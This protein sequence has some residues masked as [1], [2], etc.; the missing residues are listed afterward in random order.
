[1]AR[2]RRTRTGH[3]RPATGPMNGRPSTD[4]GRAQMRRSRISAPAT[5]GRN[6]AARRSSSGWIR[7]GSGS[8]GRKVDP[9]VLKP[10]ALA[11]L[12]SEGGS[13]SVS[14]A[15]RSVAAAARLIASTSSSSTMWRGRVAVEPQLQGHAPGGA[16]AAPG[17]RRDRSAPRSTGR[18]HEDRVGADRLAIG[19]KDARGRTVL[20]RRP[21]RGPDHDPR[22]PLLG[23]PRPGGRRGGR[24][25][26]VPGREEDGG[27]AGSERRLGQ[28]DAR[29][30]RGAR[31]EAPARPRRGVPRARPQHRDR[32]SGAAGPP[33]I[34]DIAKSSEASARAGSASGC[35]GRG[36]PVPGRAGAGWRRG[37]GRRHPPRW[38]FARRA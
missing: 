28:H 11:R 21:R 3:R 38:R 24:R 36:R 30:G 14:S 16:D 31:A 8:D 32:G 25:D 19:E 13:S 26:R 23:Q 34:G 6:S 18:R 7:A 35:R 12:N 29:R 27:G 2:G 20:D 4:C 5:R 9:S 1:M 17:R 33:A 15:A 37:C 22:A 10:P